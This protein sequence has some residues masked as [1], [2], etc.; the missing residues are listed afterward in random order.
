MERVIT[1][2]QTEY[3]IVICGAG[4]AGLA[5]A[6]QISLE[7]PDA[8]LIVIEGPRD[9]HHPSRSEERRVGKECR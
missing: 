1:Q 6:R 9:K 4:L 7:I 3:D 8:S 5:L 2:Q